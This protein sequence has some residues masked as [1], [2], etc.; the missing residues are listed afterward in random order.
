MPDKP[1][2]RLDHFFAAYRLIYEQ[3]KKIRARVYAAGY[4]P[5][6]PLAILIAQDSILEDRLVSIIR[7]LNIFPKQIERSTSTL[8]AEVSDKITKDIDRRNAGFLKG[9]RAQVGD[10]VDRAIQQSVAKADIRFFR[11]AAL[12]LA[13]VILLTAGLAGFFGY[14]SG[15]VDT[16]TIAADGAAVATRPDATTWLKIITS[17]R[18]V[19]AVLLEHCYNDGPKSLPQASGREACAVPLFVDAGETPSLGTTAAYMESLF[20]WVPSKI[21]AWVLVLSSLCAGAGLGVTLLQ[22]TR[23]VRRKD[24]E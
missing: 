15:R 6:D 23:W 20:V 9:L 8:S 22:V 16:R 12:H 14:V 3:K 4:G 7:A 18:N 5:D 19:D 11:R 21:T 1:Y 24:Q 10:D 13:L 17:N 2:D